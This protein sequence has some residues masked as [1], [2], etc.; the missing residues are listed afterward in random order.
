MKTLVYK[1]DDILELYIQ[2]TSL[3]DILAIRAVQPKIMQTNQTD[4]TIAVMKCFPTSQQ[5]ISG[6]FVLLLNVALFL[7]KGS[8]HCLLQPV[9]Q[10]KVPFTQ[11]TSSLHMCLSP[12]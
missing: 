4:L 3:F 6:V 2:N 10:H 8:Q 5:Y 11:S 1:M 9:K 7:S 12:T